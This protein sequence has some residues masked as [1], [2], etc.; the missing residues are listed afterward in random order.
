MSPLG[1]I[2]FKDRPFLPL[3]PS[4]FY[5]AIAKIH[6]KAKTGST[7]GYFFKKKSFVGYV[8]P[9]F[10]SAKWQDFGPQRKADVK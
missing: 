10:F 9:F 1:P 3:A 8:L 4:C 7:F 2:F 5:I 6:Q